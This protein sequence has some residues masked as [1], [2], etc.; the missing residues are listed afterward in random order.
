TRDAREAPTAAMAAAWA[1]VGQPPW[2]LD[3]GR[4]LRPPTSRAR[5]DRAS[6]RNPA[7]RHDVPLHFR[8]FFRREL[9]RRFIDVLQEEIEF[10]NG[11][12][13][14]LVELQ[15]AA[16]RVMRARIARTAA[17]RFFKRASSAGSVADLHVFGG[18]SDLHGRAGRVELA[19]A[20]ECRQRRGM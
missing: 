12:A 11:A 4:R 14:V 2:W 1:A 3:G 20:I 7:Q 17:N 19:S 18:Q 15:Q 5:S 6:R 10:T 13:I 9:A 16:V 8:D